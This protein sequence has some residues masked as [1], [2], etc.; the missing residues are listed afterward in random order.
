MLKLPRPLSL[1]VPLT[2]SAVAIFAAIAYSSH[3]WNGY[4]WAR[5]RN[6]FTLKVADNLTSSV[7]RFH[8]AQASKDWNSGNTPV[9]TAII[10]GPSGNNRCTMVAGTVQVCNGTYGNTDWL[11]LA[12]INLATGTKYITQG[13]VKLNDSYFDTATYNN[14]NERQ[15]VVCQELAHTFGL[16]HQSTSGISL[17]TCMDY[18]SNTGAYAN[19]MLSTTPNRH[20]FDQLNLI[21]QQLDN[22]TTVAATAP[23]VLPAPEVTDD[24]N[25]WGRLVSQSSNGRNSTYERYTSNGCKTITHVYWT[26]EAAERGPSDDHRYGH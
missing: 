7:W 5:T 15:H 14:P 4:H 1:L 19:S 13:S 25:S 2:F 20:D 26:E 10:A 22:T 11:G 8:L 21:Y 18:F 23:M 3:S 6:P 12:S 16:D 24:P 9:M 17:N